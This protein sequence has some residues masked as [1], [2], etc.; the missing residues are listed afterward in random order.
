MDLVIAAAINKDDTMIEKVIAS[1][2]GSHPQAQYNFDRKFILFDGYEGCE[3]F[4][5]MYEAQKKVI[6]S[7]YPDFEIIEFDKNIYFREMINHICKISTSDRLFIIQD[8]VSIPP[9][10]LKQIEIQMNAV[11]DLKLLCF[12]H[13]YIGHEGTH[14]YQPFD[15]TYPLP[16]IKC[17][18]WSERIFICDRLNMLS[19]LEQLPKNNKQTK[20]F[21]D[22]IYFHAMKSSEWRN[23]EY[24]IKKEEYWKQ[25]GCYYH[26]DIIHK[27]LCAKRFNC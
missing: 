19:L 2:L 25:W 1:I 16:F 6:T 9:I 10:D 24:D 3:L 21:I 4:R 18:G 23:D 26:H 12:P 7:K 22:M 17:H 20:R 14:W 5:D 15:D 27:H 11:D 13:K 8:D